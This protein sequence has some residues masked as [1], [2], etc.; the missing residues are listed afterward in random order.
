MK[1]IAILLLVT[2]LCLFTIVHGAETT[3]AAK[4]QP[5]IGL[6]FNLGFQKAYCDVLHTGA[7]LAGEF[8]ARFYLGKYFDLSFGLGYG[9]LN[10][11]FTYNTFQ[12]SLING[13]LKAN[14]HLTKPGKFNP[15]VSIGA[16][17]VSFG[18]TR[19]KPW[20]IGSEDFEDERFF[21][22][23][24]I[25]GGGMEVMVTP[26]TAINLLADYRFSTGDALDGAELGKSKDGYLNTRVG[27]TYYLGKR[28][29]RAEPSDADLLALSGTEYGVTSGAEASGGN[30]KLAMF[31]AKLDK[32]EASDTEL[33]M[34]QYVRLKSRVDE[35]NGLIENKDEELDDLKSTLTFKNQR[36][37]DLETSLQRT[38]TAPY[39]AGGF[40]ANYEEALRLFYSRNYRSAINGFSDLMS[41][42]PDH[43]LVSNCQY[44]IGECLF[45]LRE[46]SSAADAFQKVFT[47][48]HTTKRDDATIMLGRCHYNMNERDKAK[49][50]FQAL[51][52]EYPES[53]YTGKARQWLS[54]L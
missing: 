33:S 7:G 49:S 36:I 28:P 34:E 52:D 27:F 23:S 21:D 8:M 5:N 24:F 14:I 53:E 25:Y 26:Q 39:T 9:T 35:L 17:V 47:Y 18:Y 29:T 19:N 11:G 20:A 44:W 31:E 45:G 10:D 12:T 54:R 32:L 13:D 1:H 37:A 4:E 43:D 42:Y 30:E 16:G 48:H 15:Y 40:S 2:C 50:Y 46:Y 3:A 22:G 41:R 51:I 38:G 6:G